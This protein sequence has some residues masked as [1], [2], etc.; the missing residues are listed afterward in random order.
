MYGRGEIAHPPGLSH[1]STDSI[2]DVARTLISGVGG[3]DSGK[4]IIMIAEEFELGIAVNHIDVN[5]EV[6]MA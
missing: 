4:L 6:K 3:G 1:I 2:R 5:K